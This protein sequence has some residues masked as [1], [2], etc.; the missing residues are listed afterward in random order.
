MISPRTVKIVNANVRT[1]GSIG[2]FYLAQFE[3]EVRDI[4]PEDVDEKSEIIRLIQKA[5]FETRGIKSVFDVPGPV[6][7]LEEGEEE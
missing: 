2:V 7:P 5:G 4:L 6:K 3:L 1:N